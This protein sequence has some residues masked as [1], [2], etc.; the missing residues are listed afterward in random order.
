MVT[1]SFA[2]GDVM[3]NKDSGTSG[4]V[5][6]G[7]F[8][9]YL[10]GAVIGDE[11]RTAA[12]G[13]YATG[14]VR[15]G[16]TTRGSAVVYA[17]GF[18]GRINDTTGVGSKIYDS[19]A[20]GAVDAAGDGDINAGGM[21]GSAGGNTGT[22]RQIWRSYTIGPVTVSAGAA[23]YV[24]GF[25]GIGAYTEI[26]DCYALGD[27]D[28]SGYSNARVGGL[29]GQLSNAA[30]LRVYAAGTVKAVTIT[31]SG[32]ASA[33][34]IRGYTTTGQITARAAALNPWVR[35][36]APSRNINRVHGSCSTNGTLAGTG[37]YAYSSMVIWTDTDSDGIGETDTTPNSLDATGANGASATSTDFTNKGWWQTNMNFDFSGD[38]TD[39]GNGATAG[40]DDTWNWGATA[41]ILGG[42]T[43]SYPYPSLHGLPL[44]VPAGFAVL[45]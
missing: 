18:A 23:A 21:S 42:G 20:T 34:G 8:V 9:G 3:V 6:A 2:E 5:N 13:A 45:P 29:A 28:A 1:G 43:M 39:N 19:Y 38:A 27:V 40:E 14:N 44:Y 4:A 7:G 41:G 15:V 24:G 32:A 31:S 33:S 30:P 11:D 36:W 10:N 37:L 22:V 25:I 35:A 26:V 16:Q 17:S 12:F